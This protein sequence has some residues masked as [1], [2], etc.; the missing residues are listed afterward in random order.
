MLIACSFFAQNS[1]LKTGIHIN[2]VTGIQTHHDHQEEEIMFFGIGN[3]KK[4]QVQT[5][6]EICLSPRLPHRIGN[7]Q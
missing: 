4:K 6:A 5:G 2:D 1:S 3:K 7:Q